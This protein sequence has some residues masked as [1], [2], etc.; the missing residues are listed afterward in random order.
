MGEAPPSERTYITGLPKDIDSDK[1]KETLGSYGTIKEVKVTSPG[2][3]IVTFASVDEAKWVVDNLDGNMP[4]GMKEP[5]TVKFANPQRGGWGQGGG[6]GGGWKG[7]RSSPYGGKGG[8]NGGKGGSIQM[9]KTSLINMNILP[10]G[11]SSKGRSDAQ[12]LYVRGLLAD[13]TDSDL[14]DIFRHVTIIP[15]RGVKATLTPKA[16][17]VQAKTG[18]GENDYEKGKILKQW[19]ESNAYR[20]RLLNQGLGQGQGQ[21]SC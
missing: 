10:G 9:L 14:H 6:Q 13:T 1:L 18:A 15:P 21:L 8:D 4:E 12:Q 7:E 2:V 5:I 17:A 20:V 19:D 16:N 3:A 11:K